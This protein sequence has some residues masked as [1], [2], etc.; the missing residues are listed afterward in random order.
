MGDVVL[1]DD[2]ADSGLLPGGAAHL[3][4]L[5]VDSHHKRSTDLEKRSVVLV[6][7]P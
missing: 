4:R 5:P 1:V 2:L 3:E 7:A 6:C